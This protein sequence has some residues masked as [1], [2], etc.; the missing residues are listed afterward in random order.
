MPKGS[1]EG[2]P[3]GPRLRLRLP[4]GF[5]YFG[6]L[7]LRRPSTFRRTLTLTLT[8]TTDCRSGPRVNVNVKGVYSPAVTTEPLAERVAAADT[9]A[10]RHRV[11]RPHQSLSE[12][13][14]DGDHDP[15][16][17]HFGVVV[18]GEP[19]SVGSIYSEPR[20]GGAAPGWRIR[21]MA[22]ADGR[23]GSGL[24]AAV[25]AACL[26]HSEANG[27][28]EVW[29]NARIRALPLYERAGFSAVSPEFELPGI[30]PHVVMARTFRENNA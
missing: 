23:R 19:A 28:G 13:D 25:L 26:A 27:G 16:T 8:L 11:L 30:G 6:V 2:A 18:D 5:R 24:G 1:F 3:R 14:Y 12:M 20:D 15:L 4:R 10:L 29:C 7:R 21:G 17:A 9:H 22:T